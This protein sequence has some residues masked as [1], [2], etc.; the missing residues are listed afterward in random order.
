MKMQLEGALAETT[1]DGNAGETEELE[2][3]SFFEIPAVFSSTTLT[4]EG[5]SNRAIFAQAS[6]RF[7]E[8]VFITPGVRLEDNQQFGTD[9]NARIAAAYLHRK[10]QT[11]IRASWGTGIT[12]PRLDQNFGANG[13]RDLEPEQAVG[14]DAGVDQ[15]LFEDQVRVSVTYFENRLQDMI[16]FESSFAPPFGTYIN[17]GD[18]ITRGIEAEAEARLFKIV[19]IGASYTYL[20]TRA[21]DVDAP[22]DSAPTLIEDE[23]F[24]RRPAHSGRA[25][26]GVNVQDTAGLFIDLNYVGRREDSS[27]TD[28][29]ATLI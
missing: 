2:E 6:F 29:R 15:W 26:V 5:R 1:T 21:T 14:W 25:Y 27:F 19:T 22:A 17:G 10:T 3:T 23:V 4:D 16:L 8:R 12:E 18:G 24:L 11:K 28:R 9:P 7:W 13:N 20:R